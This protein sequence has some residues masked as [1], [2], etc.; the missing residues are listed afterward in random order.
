[1]EKKY[2][3]PERRRHKRYPFEYLTDYCIS[4]RRSREEQYQK[5]SSGNISFGGV[6]LYINT[7]FA[8]DD[9]LEIEV[10]YDGEKQQ[11]LELQ[12]QVR[13]V[14]EACNPQTDQK[15]Y[16]VGVQFCDMSQEQ[17]DNLKE[18]LLKYIIKDDDTIRDLL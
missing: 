17:N 2:T 15:E 9:S 1:M 11:T 5:V 14:E 18:F 8:M 3:G 10:S 16:S 6:L 12:G 7:P 4:F 13:W